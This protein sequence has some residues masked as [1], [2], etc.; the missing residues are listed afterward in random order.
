MPPSSLQSSNP[1]GR[2]FLI[3]GETF[4]IPGNTS[5][6]IIHA[7]TVFVEKAVLV[8]GPMLICFASLIIAG[9]S[10]IFF[11]IILPMMKQ[12]Y[13]NVPSG[14]LIIG[15]HIAMVLFLLIEII[16]N[17]Y[18]CVTT[19]SKGPN[20]DRVAREMAEA[21]G[22][23]FPETPQE[24]ESFRRDME[25]KLSLRMKRRQQRAREDKRSATSNEAPEDLDISADNSKSN[26]K[27]RKPPASIK[28][29]NAHAKVKTAETVR[30]WMLMA[31]DEWSF[32]HKSN[33]PKP[34]RAHYDHVSKTLTL[35][36]DHYC[37]WMFNVG[38]NLFL[39]LIG[40]LVLMF[41]MLLHDRAAM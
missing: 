7:I 8:L 35:C 33:Q 17:Y 13:A 22:F 3:C 9:L 1:S 32:C 39:P 40:N 27:K 37:P 11:T 18:M 24:V 16:F 23:V 10:N 34:P 41:I 19:R 2:R 21:T 28:Y 30:S 25:D 14:N 15:C 12:K 31:P 26:M 6:A 20:Y 5:D 36:L 29:I 38:K 4:R